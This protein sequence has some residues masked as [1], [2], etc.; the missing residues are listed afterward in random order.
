MPLGT[1]GFGSKLTIKSPEAARL[2][3]G[4]K[5]KKPHNAASYYQS[6]KHFNTVLLDD[7]K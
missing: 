1:C 6:G 2:D 5:F 7:L 3:S 4:T